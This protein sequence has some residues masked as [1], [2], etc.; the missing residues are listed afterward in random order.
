MS[1][2]NLV[3]IADDLMK[4]WDKQRYIAKDFNVFRRQA[5]VEYLTL[6]EKTQKTQMMEIQKA[7]LIEDSNESEAK[8]NEG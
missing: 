7:K 3:K 1:E 2:L 5:L 8:D 6:V 4:N